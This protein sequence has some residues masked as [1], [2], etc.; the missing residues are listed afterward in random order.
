MAI[1]HG[2]DDQRVR[3][4]NGAFHQT[5]RDSGRAPAQGRLRPLQRQAPTAPGTDR[6]PSAPLLS[7]RMLFAEFIRENL[8]SGRPG[9]RQL[10]VRFRTWTGNTRGFAHHRP[11]L[12]RRGICWFRFF[13]CLSVSL[14]GIRGNNCRMHDGKL[15][16][17]LMTAAKQSQYSEAGPNSEPGGWLGHQGAIRVGKCY[18]QARFYCA[19]NSQRR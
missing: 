16:A 3:A 8:D 9:M 6:R 18:P 19:V 11:P 15:A 4:V 14:I 2:P 1:D 10:R 13:C 12:G 7:G 17:H 5:A